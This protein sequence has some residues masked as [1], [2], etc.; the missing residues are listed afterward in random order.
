MPHRIVLIKVPPPSGKFKE[1]AIDISYTDLDD[2]IWDNLYNNCNV[3]LLVI[4]ESLVDK[5]FRCRLQK[6]VR[7]LEDIAKSVKVA[8]PSSFLQDQCGSK[9]DF[10]CCARNIIY[11]HAKMGNSEKIINRLWE[12]ALP[13]D[14]FLMKNL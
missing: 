9:K 2:N 8:T 7:N 1:H 10:L 3:L 13:Y 11:E 6:T 14:E 4:P 5:D 12:N